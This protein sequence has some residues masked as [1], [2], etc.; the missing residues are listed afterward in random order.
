MRSSSCACSAEALAYDYL[1]YVTEVGCQV[2]TVE[3]ITELDDVFQQLI[4]TQED[5][6]SF[7]DRIMGLLKKSGRNPDVGHPFAMAVRLVDAFK[8]D[9]YVPLISAPIPLQTT[10]TRPGAD[11]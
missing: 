10:T 2:L 11:D 6:P 1:V 9:H 3:E 8:L 4:E 7:D 5:D